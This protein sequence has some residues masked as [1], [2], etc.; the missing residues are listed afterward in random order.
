[1]YGYILITKLKAYKPNII[2]YSYYVK[3]GKEIFG[4]E[5]KDFK[6]EID[7]NEINIDMK[8]ELNIDEDFN[9]E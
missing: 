3:N 2:F 5:Y 8:I 1:M 4:L 6:P 9:F 7:Y